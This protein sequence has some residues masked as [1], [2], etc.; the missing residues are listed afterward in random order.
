MRK[1]INFTAPSTAPEDDPEATE[2]LLHRRPRLE[3]VAHAAA[4]R[5]VDRAR[6]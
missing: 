3:D 5:R 1:I 2:T 6:P 4:F